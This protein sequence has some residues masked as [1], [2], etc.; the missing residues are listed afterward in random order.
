MLYTKSNVYRRQL[1]YRRLACFSN[2]SYMYT[3]RYDFE[4]LNM[5]SKIDD[6]RD[7]H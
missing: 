7:Q 2:D 5:R 1:V 6:Q 4:I 3:V